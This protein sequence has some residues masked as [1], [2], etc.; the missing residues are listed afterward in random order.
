MKTFFKYDFYFQSIMFIAYIIG[1][2]ITEHYDLV[3]ENYWLLFY[4]IIGGSQLL[5]YLVRFIVKYPKNL[6][7]VL[8]GIL[9]L[10]VWLIFFYYIQIEKVGGIFFG[11][12]FSGFIYSPFLAISY[13]IYTYIIYKSQK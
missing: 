2:F 9:I 10:P 4:Y 13:I 6:M 11:I 12:L 8:Y 7:Y 5:S 1:W 3:S